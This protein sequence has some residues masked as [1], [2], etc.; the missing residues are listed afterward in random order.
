[1]GLEALNLDLLLFCCKSFL[2]YSDDYLTQRLLEEFSETDGLTGVDFDM[3]MGSAAPFLQFVV[4][5]RI[6]R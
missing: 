3:A 5:S 1:M 2:N 4:K 6:S